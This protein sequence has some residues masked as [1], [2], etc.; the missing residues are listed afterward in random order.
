M[1]YLP[2][3]WPFKFR[4][5][6]P[7]HILLA[8]LSI[9]GLTSPATAQMSA[10][11]P[12]ANISDSPTSDSS[13]SA[14]GESRSFGSRLG[15]I[16]RTIGQDEWHFIKAPFTKKAIPWDIL[17]VGGTVAL[18]ATDADEELLH[19][20]P[21]DWTDTSHNISNACIYGSS[22]IAAG[23]YLTGLATKNEH[24]QET[25]IRTAEALADSII[26]Y[27]VMKVVTQRQRPFSGSGE[28]Q[29]FAG[30]WRHGSFPSGHSM[31]TWTIASTVAHRYHSIPLDI[32]MYGVATTM[33][34]VRITGREHFPSDVFVGSIFGYLIG[35]YV[36][37]KPEDGFPIRSQS[38]F[39]HATNAVLQ[40]VSIGVQ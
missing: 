3:I 14:N 26:M 37:H 32:L 16:G 38:K 33:S 9:A 40:H 1:E 25:G 5:I 39:R 7:T 29:F 20:V 8:I 30:N 11:G 18:A 19:R 35:D 27:G 21:P 2:Q 28:G 36:A 6:S 22:A 10:A 17:V 24:A 4:I 31:F 15:G 23:I 13:D 34:G 12:D